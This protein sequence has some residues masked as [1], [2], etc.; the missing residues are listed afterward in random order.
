MYNT[1][2][3]DISQTFRRQTEVEISRGVEV[4]DDAWTESS[5]EFGRW[6]LNPG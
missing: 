4:Q 2:E 3:L 1:F 5:R 6:W